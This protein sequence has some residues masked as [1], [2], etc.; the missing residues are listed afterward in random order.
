MDELSK[1]EADD[2]A[3]EDSL[4]KSQLLSG[5]EA[6]THLSIKQIWTSEFLEIEVLSK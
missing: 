5:F 1:L 3:S 6:C 4:P 2:K